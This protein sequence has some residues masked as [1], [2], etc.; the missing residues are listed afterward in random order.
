MKN[1]KV[2]LITIVILLC[3]FLP[4]TVIGFIF[5]DDK[6]LLDENPRH[7]LYYKGKVWFYDE[8]D[9]LLSSYECQ[10]E[11]CELSVPTIDDDTYG[12][13]YYKGTISSVPVE[14]NSYTFITDGAVLYLYNVK[15]GTTLQ[16]YKSIK[17]YNTK[18]NNNNYILQNSDGLW[19]VLTVGSTLSSVLP[20][21][22][23]FV[24]L[25]NKVD[26]KGILNS[27]KFIVLKD[28]K[29]YIV[30]SDNSAITGYI[31]D[32]I[33]DYTDEYVISKNSERIRIHSYQNFEYLTNYQIKDYALE[34]NYIAI[35]ID[36]FI[37]IYN[38]L[39]TNY[40]KSI[41]LTTSGELDLEKEDNKLIVKINNEIIETIEL[42]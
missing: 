20:F 23:D 14:D 7:D 8:N 34:D 31:D 36:G 19:G 18:I 17:N 9:K 13:N 28:S 3:I 1:K 29:W 24:G 22:Y 30:D 32:P 33:I 21:E 41:P 35:V 42:N 5:K 16:S 11:V 37:L 6:N 40:I 10:T 26:D 12:I 4:L 39:N 27:D 2:V 25:I 15:N 38:S